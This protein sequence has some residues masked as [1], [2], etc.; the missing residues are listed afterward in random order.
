MSATPEWAELMRNAVEGHAFELHTAMPG[1][2]VRVHTSADGKH[3]FVDVQPCL[4]RAVPVDADDPETT[5]TTP[6]VEE[7]LPVLPM[8]P[9]AFQ[10]GGGFFLSFPLQPGDF[11]LL[12]FAERSIDRWIETASKANQRTVSTGDVG[13]HVLEG[14]I[15]IPCGPAPRANLL[16]DVSGTDLVIGKDGGSAIR[17]KPNGE[18]HLGDASPA[19]ALA[20]ATKVATELNRVKSD[21]DSLKIKLAAHFHTSVAGGGPTSPPT[22]PADF[23]AWVPSTPASTA[24]DKVKAD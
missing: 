8:V 10:Q 14:A 2:I 16:A 13:V 22:S 4:R 5:A 12:I 1:Q 3:Q 17:I 18:I 19:S 9:V 24:S 23:S 7:D 6:F 11:V 21:L 15:A 20:L